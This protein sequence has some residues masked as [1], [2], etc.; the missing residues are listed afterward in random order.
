[1]T[2]RTAI[3][4]AALLLTLLAP[5]AA[6]PATA[7]P[8]GPRLQTAASTLA[9]AFRCTGDPATSARRTVLLVHGTGATPA[10]NFNWNYAK[11][12]PARGFPVCTITIPRRG[13]GD[14]Q[15]N[16]EYVVWAIRRASAISGRKIAVIGHSQ[17]AFL[18]SYAL[19]VWPDLGRKVSDLISY[20]GAI[21][22]GTDQAKVLCA[23]PC[24][25]AF[26][27]FTPGSNLLTQIAKR[28]LPEGPAYTAFSTRLDE[29]VT[30]QPMASRISAPGARNYVMQDLCPLSLGEHLTI[31]GERAARQLTFDALTHAGPGKVSR[32]SKRQ[33]GFAPETAAALVALP[34]FGIGIVS[35]YPGLAT[36]TEPRLRCY[37]TRTCG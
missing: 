31:I 18:P 20:A 23:L 22:H 21:T 36:T 26:Q 29:V 15:T 10:E 6:Q 30:P 9:S 19:R 37:W 1:M 8:P 4:L 5:L 7:A 33:C 24:A 3:V 2:R 35:T 17:G 13:L 12:L 14:L 27:Q 25:Q 11:W 28:P 16:V 34:T 32:I